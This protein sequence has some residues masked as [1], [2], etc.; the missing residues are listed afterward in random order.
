MNS[1]DDDLDKEVTR[2]RG[3]M[4]SLVASDPWHDGSVPEVVADAWQDVQD[5]Y[6]RVID[7][8]DA[9]PL[10]TAEARKVVHA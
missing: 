8:M 5:A 3:G 4:G 2:I 10:I 7:L 6:C 9:F 1:Q